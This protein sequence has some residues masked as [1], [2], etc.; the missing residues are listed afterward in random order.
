M[1]RTIIRNS[2]LLQILYLSL[3]PGNGMSHWSKPK[4]ESKRSL[5]LCLSAKG[6]EP[7]HHILAKKMSMDNEIE[8]ANSHYIRSQTCHHISPM[9]N[10]YIAPNMLKWRGQ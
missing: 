9:S 1:V 3:M 5:I 7:E 8:Q 6:E 4:G 10:F 2:F